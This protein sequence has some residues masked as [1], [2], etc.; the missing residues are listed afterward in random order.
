MTGLDDLEVDILVIVMSGGR[1]S[2]VICGSAMNLCHSS[3]SSI[4][5]GDKETPAPAA[6]MLERKAE[7]GKVRGSR[8]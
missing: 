5:F 2:A 3:I 6:A 7:E 1:Q 8:R 4:E